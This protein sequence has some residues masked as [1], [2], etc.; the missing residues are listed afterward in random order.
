[1]ALYAAFGVL[2]R[3]I[4]A[5][6]GYAYGV[7]TQLDL[8]IPYAQALARARSVYVEKPGMQRPLARH[9][10]DSPVPQWWNLFAVRVLYPRASSLLWPRYGYGALFI[11][12]ALAAV[13]AALL[14][15]GF[16]LSCTRPSFAAAIAFGG[17][18]LPEAHAI[19]R[20]D[21][22]DM[23]AY[24]LLVASL[25][26]M[27]RFAR[28]GRGRWLF[29][30]AAAATL[31]SF[32]RPVPY[33]IVCAALPLLFTSMRRQGA[34]LAGLGVALCGVVEIALNV[35]HADVPA[36]PNEWLALAH[37]FVAFA[38][39]WYAHPASFVALAALWIKRREPE[40][41]LA[42]GAWASALLTIVVNPIPGD[43]PRVVLLP[44]FL[45]LAIGMAYTAEILIRGYRA[46]SAAR[47]SAP[48]DRSTRPQ[49][50]R[51]SS[52]IR[53]NAS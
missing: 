2:P 5:F 18:L 1:M 28:T 46:T 42:L 37:T 26:A 33:I 41:L 16:L 10:I 32:T 4:Y 6:D 39:W 20:C 50:G 29:A 25:W 34:L 7:R 17:A 43:V 15:Y 11:V 22:T 36:P 47:L 45:S 3:P 49:G 27:A 21:L 53:T 13:A 14:T 9:W 30:A 44:S 48:R 8:G 35:T 23:P 38:T 52:R 12:S 24:A 19:A 40:A 31:L 51:R